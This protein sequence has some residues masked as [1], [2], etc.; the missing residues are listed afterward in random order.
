MVIYEGP[1]MID[2]AP[3]VAIATGIENP[4]RN[5]KTGP[6]V[7]V[8]ILRQ[9]VSPVD[10]VK[11]GADVSVCGTC[12]H[13][14]HAGGACYVVPGHAPQSIWHAYKRGKYAQVSPVEAGRIL[15]GR[16]VRLGAYGDPGALPGSVIDPIAATSAE[17]LAYSHAWRDRPD[18]AAVAMASV[19]SLAERLEAKSKGWRTFRVTVGDKGKGE[20]ICPSADESKTSRPINCLECKACNGTARGYSGDIVIEVHGSRAVRFQESA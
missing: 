7:Q 9:D 4:S 6:V 1:S 2:G 8:W 19:D 20:S 5:R 18:L 17:I 12:V 16:I 11:S 3:I 10:A 13:R 15:S 14:H